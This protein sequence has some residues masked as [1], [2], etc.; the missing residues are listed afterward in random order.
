MASASA[1]MVEFPA[2]IA[3]S[4]CLVAL[5]KIFLELESELKI[6]LDN[7]SASD[8][9]I[10]KLS[11]R[12]SHLVL[13][14]SIFLLKT[15][16][17]KDIGPL[18]NEVLMAITHL[19]CVLRAKM[20]KDGGANLNKSYVN[21]GENIYKTYRSLVSTARKHFLEEKGEKKAEESTTME[22]KKTEKKQSIGSPSTDAARRLVEALRGSLGN[23]SESAED[24]IKRLT[25]SLSLP[26]SEGEATAQKLGFLTQLIQ[27]AREEIKEE[28]D[29]TKNGNAEAM[30]TADKKRIQNVY[31]LVQTGY[32][33]SRRMLLLTRQLQLN[34]LNQQEA[35]GVMK[36]Y[37]DAVESSEKMSLHI[38]EMCAGVFEQEIKEVRS[39]ALKLRDVI[40][41]GA[42]SL[43]KQKAFESL[44]PTKDG[45]SPKGWVE[46]AQ[47]AA[48]AF[49][50]SILSAI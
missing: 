12:N 28:S 48:K 9:E 47:K 31:R 32:A 11:K 2:D 39:H 4:R 16:G 1:S 25:G 33:V 46:Y 45:K 49:T 13:K 18:A 36:F 50:K 26:M 27:D 5:E 42:Q 38:D 3:P 44:P 37:E 22:K 17:L 40:I 23:K 21:V 7:V 29:K 6:P 19:N 41:S 10:I 30:S 8:N 20:L 35:K 34:K 15:P 14:L 24:K 43:G